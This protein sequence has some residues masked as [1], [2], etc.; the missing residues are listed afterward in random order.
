MAT[1]QKA[2]PIYLSGPVSLCLPMHPPNNNL[3]LSVGQ[4]RRVL[5]PIARAWKEDAGDLARL[6]MLRRKPTNQPVGV[7]VEM[8]LTH[9]RDV[10]SVKVLLDCL[11]GVVWEDDSQAQDLHIRKRR[12]RRGEGEARSIVTVYPLEATE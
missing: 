6:A 11:T 5:S 1:K 10:D 4:R 8:L 9:D 7:V 12:L 3:Y 2:L